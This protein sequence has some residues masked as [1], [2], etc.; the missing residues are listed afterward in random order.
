MLRRNG[1]EAYFAGLPKDVSRAAT[2]ELAQLLESM[3]PDADNR[4]K[5]LHGLIATGDVPGLDERIK[6]LMDKTHIE[7]QRLSRKC[8]AL[9]SPRTWLDR[10]AL[11]DGGTYA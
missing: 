10:I 2:I 9:P 3:I 5:L 11:N 1:A 7:M 4:E 6:Q 8:H